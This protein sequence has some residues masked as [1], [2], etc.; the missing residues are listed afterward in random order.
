MKYKKSHCAGS[1]R[2]QIEHIA[3]A[4]NT[5]SEAFQGWKG[6]EIFV[7]RLL[8]RPSIWLIHKQCFSRIIISK[9]SNDKQPGNLKTRTDGAVLWGG[10]LNSRPEAQHPTS[11]LTEPSLLHAHPSPVG[12]VRTRL[13]AHEVLDPHGGEQRPVHLGAAQTVWFFEEWIGEWEDFFL[14]LSL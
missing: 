14:G 6:I 1:W 4:F 9:S 12:L 13:Q 5:I 11:A 2:R 10:R 8:N 7:F 3:N